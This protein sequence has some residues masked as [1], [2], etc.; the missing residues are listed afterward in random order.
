MATK[1]RED[2]R[3]SYAYGAL[4]NGASPDAGQRQYNPLHT[5]CQ[6]LR[7]DCTVEC[8]FI[9][10]APL[11]SILNRGSMLAI[12]DGIGMDE[13][14]TDR[15]A[16]IDGRLLREIAEYGVE[17]GLST[18]RLTSLANGT[19]HLKETFPIFFAHPRSLQPRETSF[20]VRDPK[21]SLRLFHVVNGTLNGIGKLAVGGTATIQNIKVSVTQVMDE[22]ET[23]RPF[24]IPQYRMIQVPVTQANG[25]LDVNIVTGQYLRALTVMQ[26]SDKGEVT[27]II[28]ALAIMGDMR[29]LLGPNLHTWD[30]LARRQEIDNGGAVY[31]PGAYYR[32]N[33]QLNGR[34]S[35]IWNPA[36]DNNLKIRFDCKPTAAAG[37][38]VSMIR[39]LLEELVIDPSARTPDGKPLTDPLEIPV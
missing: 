2:Q 22:Y 37:A 4:V 26:D 38:T 27:D 1:I 24:F 15:I 29:Q 20:M 31:T 13:N 17:S 18:T 10:T 28:N 25:A 19:T 14:G 36:Q 9:T 3:Q 8:D 32:K 7:L 6:S 35:E 11:T 21:Q 16:P 33:F 5:T 23:G 39:I 30:N 34:L 12:F